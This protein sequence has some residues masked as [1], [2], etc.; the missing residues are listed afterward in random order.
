MLNVQNSIKEGTEI[1]FG[2]IGER[3]SLTEQNFHLFGIFKVELLSRDLSKIEIWL[4]IVSAIDFAYS[5][6]PQILTVLASTV[7]L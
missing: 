5:G 1:A 7:S 3:K 4:Y 2:G 6:T